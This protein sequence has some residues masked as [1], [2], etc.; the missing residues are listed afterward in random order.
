MV[1]PSL[2]AQM[3]PIEPLLSMSRRLGC[4]HLSLFGSVLRK[5]LR[6]VADVDLHLV[7]PRM[8]R[9]AFGALAA[10]TEATVQGLAALDGRP[11]RVELRHG[12]FKPAPGEP[13]DLQLHLLLDDDVSLARLPCANLA[14]RAAT[15]FLLAGEPLLGTRTSCDAP[16]TWL[17]E[18][19]AE[20]TRWRDALAAREIAFRHWV[21]DP[22][23]DLVEGRT[24]A[25]TEWDL[26]CLL[27]GAATAADLHYR[28][29]VLAAESGA[30]PGEELARPL[31]SQISA[32]SWDRARDQAIAV[33][34]RRLDHLSRL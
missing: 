12:P 28:A 27:R 20:L 10:A 30:E 22:E 32:G 13:R 8:D 15:G 5:P 19:C 24:A 25:A 29:A 34:E 7:V 14:H 2:S 18:A 23:P 31:R 33:L 6:E 1:L 4:R 9:S 3:A 16:A 17:R 26:E 21:L 11:W